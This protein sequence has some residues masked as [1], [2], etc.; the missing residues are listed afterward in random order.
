LRDG[1]GAGGRRRRRKQNK[2]RGVSQCSLAIY[3]KKD[4]KAREDF[5]GNSNISSCKNIIFKKIL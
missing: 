4:L 5:F 3:I 1:G 2:T